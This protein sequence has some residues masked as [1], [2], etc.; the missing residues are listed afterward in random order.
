[1]KNIR[2]I[3]S[4]LLLLAFTMRTGDY[5]YA[6][7][8]KVR[9]LV[10][11]KD[12][13]AA[14]LSTAEPESKYKIISVPK[15]D[16]QRTLT[17][18]KKDRNI[19]IAELDQLVYTQ[20]NTPNDTNFDKQLQD[21]SSM[22][23]L[24][25]WDHYDPKEEVIVALIDSG[26]DLFHPELKNQLVEG[27]NFINESQ[28]PMDNTGHGT[29]VAGLIGAATNNQLGISSP[30]KKV[31]LMPVKVFEGRTTY[32]STVIKGIRY[33]ADHGAD[34][35]NLSLGSYSNMMALED[36]VDYA[37]SKGALV[38]GAAGNDNQH[39]V[40]YPASYPHVLAVGSVDS[41]SLSRSTFSNYG[42]P[43]DVSA[44]G[45]NIYSTWIDGYRYMNGTSMAAAIVSSVSSMVLQNYPF[46]NG[47]QV[48]EVM[49]NSATQLP[50]VKLLGKG[51]INAE[52]ALGYVKEKNRLFG[53]TSMD[54][55]VHISRN[56]WESLE[57]KKLT[58]DG[59][60]INGTFVI[61]ASGNKFPDSLAASPLSSYLDSPILLLKGRLDEKV[62]KELDR[63]K[64]THAIIIGGKNAVSQ[65]I[66]KAIQAEAIQTMRVS[67]IDRYETAIAINNVIPYSTNKAF[68]VSGENYPDAL[69]IA[70]YSG[71]KQY[72]VL[73]VQKDKVSKSVENYLKSNSITKA[74]VIG[75]EG[76]ISK[77]VNDH[78]PSPYRI[79]GADRFE[80]NKKV[81]Q[82]F[83]N[84]QTP[85]IYFATG[86]NFPDALSISPLASRTESPVV[87]V[88]KEENSV[89]E[90]TIELFQNKNDYRILGGPG[91]VSLEKA[92]EI[93]GYMNK[94]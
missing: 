7:S 86:W 42:E 27:R 85:T 75:G 47:M 82:L 56:G 65:D 60:T 23:V 24:E 71:S 39:A 9:I 3:V 32:M 66:E 88:D 91:A 34:I 38:V 76:V 18:L 6:D 12:G 41:A 16:V 35:I 58:I 68:V 50:S 87:L 46:L 17:M 30:V 33:A 94:E 21:F 90:A 4:V 55:A 59:R 84:D 40:T 29:H 77:E 15:Q 11:T 69:S 73:F 78:L 72:P 93:D 92:W 44:P 81:H 5:T 61:I 45:S 67:G 25:A 26:I 20:S 52:A 83:S 36:A 80:T 63:L 53:D 22:K 79:Y 57:E 31:K 62:L 54:T 28:P 10:V 49:E 2:V 64:P 70:S 37:V 8:Q 51:L 48:K 89:M 1:M 43:I 14:T 13:E 19:E 74:Y